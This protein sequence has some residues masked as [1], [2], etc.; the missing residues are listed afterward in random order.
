MKRREIQTFS[1][2]FQKVGFEPSPAGHLMKW[3]EVSPLI[4]YSIKV[5]G[6]HRLLSQIDAE[7]ARRDR[8]G[9]PR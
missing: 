2:L 7:L 9:D 1:A 5:F 8:E 3:R 4:S 6:Y